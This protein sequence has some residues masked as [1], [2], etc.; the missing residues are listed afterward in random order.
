MSHDYYEIV[1]VFWQFLLIEFSLP[2]DRRLRT[3][4]VTKCCNAKEGGQFS[5][6]VL[7]VLVVL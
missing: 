4:A 1:G 5:G 3:V 7:K 2:L 6:A